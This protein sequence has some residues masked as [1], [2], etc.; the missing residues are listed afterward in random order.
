MKNW[1]AIV[2]G[3][4]L[5]KLGAVVLV[6]GIALYLGYSLAHLTPAGRTTLALGASASLL[7]TG[8]WFERNPT[9]RLFALGLI[10]AGWAALYATSYA[11]W[12]LPAARIID[13]PL[14]GSLG[15]L[16][17]A[18]AMIG[19][20]LSY[21]SQ[22]AASVAYFAAFAALA[23]TPVNSFALLGAVPLAAS[24]LWLAH[25]F[26]WHAMALPGLVATYGACVARVG[27]ET[28]SAQALLVVYW[29]LFEA[30]DVLRAVRGRAGRGL[31]WV[32]PV[33]AAGFLGL[34][35]WVWL[36]RAPENLWLL[37][38]CTA[39]L[40]G[41]SAIVR[42][43]AVR[44]GYQGA[45]AVSAVLAGLA[46]AGRVPGIWV[47]AGLAI[48][49]Q[50]LYL[51]GVR[52]NAPWVRQM[53]AGWFALS[54][55]RI[56]WIDLPSGASTRVLGQVVYTWTPPLLLHAG[57][58]YLNGVARRASALFGYSATALL[59]GVLAA[60]A[61]ARML[62]FAWD[63]GGGSAVRDRRAPS[64][65]AFPL[66]GDRCRRDEPV[67]ERAVGHRGAGR[68]QFGAGLRRDVP[69]AAERRPGNL[70]AQEPA[71]D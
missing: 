65:A 26:N 42:V 46:I 70:G 36:Q 52:L 22:A 37:A 17:V 27:A 57:L 1:E 19:H 51:I 40:Y 66:P 10:G 8:L 9:Y 62:G 4:L 5:N 16:L 64:V 32:F 29:A 33:N 68:G 71:L 15:T 63:R 3:S 23:V 21:R 7:A 24:L 58:F 13:S 31:E 67:G 49:A 11:M 47:S 30:F 54:L 44:S 14:A 69:C 35:Y 56:F 38:A 28:A 53:A 20:S 34:S 61:P 55:G 48:E 6:I 18:G 41:A 43:A 45:L 60:E 2:G 59:V 50:V 25:R 39:G 12:A